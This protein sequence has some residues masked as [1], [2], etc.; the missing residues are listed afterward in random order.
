MNRAKYNIILVNSTLGPQ[1]ANLRTSH[2]HRHISLSPRFHYPNQPD[3]PNRPPVHST[4]EIGHRELDPPA[5]NQKSVQIP[6]V[7]KEKCT[8]LIIYKGRHTGVYHLF[9]CPFQDC[10]TLHMRR[11][12]E[13]V[14]WLDWLCYMVALVS[15]TLDIA[16]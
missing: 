11:L 8:L 16:N 9:I 12:W 3:S 5:E 4:I 15:K 1:L 13:L 6:I 7:Q 10:N 2:K 14:Y